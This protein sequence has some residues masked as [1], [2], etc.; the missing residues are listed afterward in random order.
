MHPLPPHLRRLTDSSYLAA[1][2]FIFLAA[3]GVQLGLYFWLLRSALRSHD[4]A[5]ARPAFTRW[6]LAAL[7]WQ[8]LVIAGTGIYVYGTARQHPAGALWIAPAIG[9]LAGTALPLQLVA[10]SALRAARR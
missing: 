10:V 7:V 3:A 1:G 6:I 5:V 2:L 4:A 8:G 9:A